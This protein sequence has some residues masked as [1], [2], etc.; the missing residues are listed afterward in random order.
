MSLRVCLTAFVLLPCLA[1]AQTPVNTQAS[2]LGT[3]ADE[4][5]WQQQLQQV[6]GYNDQQK[7]ALLEQLYSCLHSS[8]PTQRDEIGYTGWATVLRQAPPSKAVLKSYFTRFSK[9]IYANEPD[10]DGVFKPFAVLVFSELVRVDRVDPYLSDKQ[11]QLALDTVA[12]Y[13][14][15]LSDFRAFDQATGWRHGL[16]HSADV[17]LQL[18]LNPALNEDQLIQLGNIILANLSANGAPAFTHGEPLRLARAMAYTLIRPQVPLAHWQKV[19]AQHAQP[20]NFDGWGQSYKTETGLVQ[21]HNV[22]SFY[23]ALLSIIAYQDDE[24]LRVLA[25]EVAKLSRSVQ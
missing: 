1:L 11:R 24:R 18:A 12:D 22:R 14:S 13:L 17:L 25:P 10:A 16:A 23:T 8:D 20:A 2:C 4:G 7:A 5:A 9:A 3:Y 15:V 21:Q 19:L 6:E